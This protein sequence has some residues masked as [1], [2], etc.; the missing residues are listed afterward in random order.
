MGKTRLIDGFD[1][2]CFGREEWIE[3]EALECI[4]VV[5]NLGNVR[6]AAMTDVCHGLG[7]LEVS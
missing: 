4:A 3:V 6:Y 5:G 7:R 1:R 2:S